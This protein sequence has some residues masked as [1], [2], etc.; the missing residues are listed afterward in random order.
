MTVPNFYISRI[1]LLL[2]IIGSGTA[3]YGSLVFLVNPLAMPWVDLNEPVVIPLETL[4]PVQTPEQVQAELAEELLILGDR[5]ATNPRTVAIYPI[6]DQDTKALR[7]VRVYQIVGEDFWSGDRPDRIRLIKEIQVSGVPTEFVEGKASA[8][9]LP[10]SRLEPIQGQPPSRGIWF[11]AVGSTKEVTY[12]QV[13]SFFADEGV[14]LDMLNW[15]NPHGKLPE[16]T[17]FSTVPSPEPDLVIDQTS[18][19]EPLFLVYRLAATPNSTYPMQFRRLNLQELLGMPRLYSEALVLASAGLWSPALAKLDTLKNQSPN[20][21]EPAIQEQY[22]L[23]T[24]HAQITAQQ[25]SNNFSDYGKAALTLGING[26]WAEALGNLQG[27]E[28]R[29]KMV[30]E[31]LE[32]TSNLL[33]ERI[34]TA[35]AIDPSPEVVLWGSVI[36]LQGQGLVAAE[37]WLRSRWQIPDFPD[38]KGS[39]SLLRQL[40]LAPLGIESQQLIGTV[41][42][43]GANLPQDNLQIPLRPLLP[44]QVWYAVDVNVIQTGNRWRN[45]PFEAVIGRSHLA[46]WK[47]LGMERNNILAVQLPNGDFYSLI[48]QSLTVT[49]G[50]GIILLATGGADMSTSENGM[51]AIV[52]AGNL[53]IEARGKYTTLGLIEDQDVAAKIAQNVYRKL[54]E[55]GR[56]SVSLAELREKLI[57]WSVEEVNLQ[58]SESGELLLRIPRE[59]IDLGDRTYPI[60]MIFSRQGNLLF[61]DMQA[62]SLRRWRGLLPG[63]DPKQI[64]VESNGSYKSL[65]FSQP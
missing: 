64:L 26:D 36:I 21:W 46:I 13:Y 50:G 20:P 61:S 10:L 22:D 48:A 4:N 51:P 6:L 63:A 25:A 3:I 65:S 58:A 7:A 52:K 27:S 49:D 43:L 9:T 30:M 17:K 11:M 53:L 55:Y 24:Y 56:V 19:W 32:T 34:N 35:I 12:G 2:L 16:W 31:R 60:V 37:Q 28:F 47:A 44:G 41:R 62:D 14:M 1:V 59:R 45:A 29:A 15:R 18:E 38:I 23:I 33:W 8:D 57:T 42:L 54:S 39:I 40:D 5:L